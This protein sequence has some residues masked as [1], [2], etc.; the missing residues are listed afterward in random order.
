MNGAPLLLT[1]F[2][3]GR[4]FQKK[5]EGSGVVTLSFDHLFIRLLMLVRLSLQHEKQ[6]GEVQW[7]RILQEGHLA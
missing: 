4:D 1:C 6:G 7:L 3:L 5:K 2:H